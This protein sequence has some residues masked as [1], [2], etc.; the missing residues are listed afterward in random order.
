MQPLTECGHYSGVAYFPAY[1]LKPSAP[2]RRNVTVPGT[3]PWVAPRWL[4]VS[5]H[6]G[7]Q[8]K[9]I[10]GVLIQ[11]RCVFR[12]MDSG[13]LLRQAPVWSGPHRCLIERR[14]VND[15]SGLLLFPRPAGVSESEQF[16][17]GTS[18]IKI[19]CPEDIEGMRIV[20]KV[21]TKTCFTIS[22][23]VWV[24]F[25]F[26]L[27]CFLQLAREVL[28]IAAMMVKPGVT[29]EEI[30]HAVHLVRLRRSLKWVEVHMKTK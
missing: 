16:L 28:D 14:R 23:I 1:L 10:S 25:W 3:V 24:H 22:M 12:L 30:D 21:K 9:S 11:S 20:S 19:L 26:W 5:R 17:K 15:R 7:R 18:Q 2:R 8:T 27:A 6:I 29:T 13:Q 4:I